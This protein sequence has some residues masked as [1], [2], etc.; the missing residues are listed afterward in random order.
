MMLKKTLI[1]KYILDAANSMK[2]YS[3]EFFR[4]LRLVT[5]MLLFFIWLSKIG[6]KSRTKFLKPNTPSILFLNP[7]ILLSQTVGGT[8]GTPYLWPAITLSTFYCSNATLIL[9]L[10]NIQ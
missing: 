2:I 9:E 8:V 5:M 3:K 7:Y 10:N 1:L 6:F 4:E